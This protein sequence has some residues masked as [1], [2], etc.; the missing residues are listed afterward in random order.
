MKGM[1][2]LMSEDRMGYGGSEHG[3][4]MGKARKACCLEGV[5]YLLRAL[6][7]SRSAE[8]G[9]R[10]ELA[11]VRGKLESAERIINC[12]ARTGAVRRRDFVSCLEASRAIREG[13]G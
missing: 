3:L 2:K 13:G 10:M 7:N 5:G 8:I 11:R 9:V 4:L 1:V 6:D 12:V